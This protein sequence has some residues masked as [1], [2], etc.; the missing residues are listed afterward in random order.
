MKIRFQTMSAKI[1]NILNILGEGDLSTSRPA[2]QIVIISN[3][4]F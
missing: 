4:Q 3:S 2:S 1:L